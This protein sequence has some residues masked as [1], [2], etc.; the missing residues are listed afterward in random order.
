[1]L[2]VS[3]FATLY[4]LLPRSAAASTTNVAQCL[5]LSRRFQDR[6]A[7]V[8]ITAPLGQ[9]RYHSQS[10]SFIQVSLRLEGAIRRLEPLKSRTGN[11]IVN[12]RREAGACV[13]GPPFTRS[14][15]LHCLLIISILS[16]S[17]RAPT[18]HIAPLSYNQ[19]AAFRGSLLALHVGCIG[20]ALIS[21]LRRL[22]R[23]SCILS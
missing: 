17:T 2:Q 9:R 10:R 5:R 21:R 11:T 18:F 16:S 1:M 4:A 3:A 6:R 20:R 22:Q 14:L 8:G 15:P 7:S 13:R 19:T 12:F 23:H